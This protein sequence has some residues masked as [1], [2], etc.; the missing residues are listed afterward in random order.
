MLPKTMSQIYIASDHRGWAL[1]EELKKRFSDYSWQDLGP[2]TS[3][4]VDYPEYA[5]KVCEKMKEQN[6]SRGVLICG[7]GQG[8][9]M[10]ANRYSYIRAALCWNENVASLARKHN[11]ANVLCL[12]G[13]L[14]D[15]ELC[16]NICKVFME[17]PFEEGRHLRRIQ[18]L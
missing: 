2:T 15:F 13:V 6:E 11:D 7:A 16:V 4:P 17:T 1:K 8:M 10:K 9:S 5:Q 3:A 14:L 12:A 18:Q